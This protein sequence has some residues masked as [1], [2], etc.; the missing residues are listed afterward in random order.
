[1][2]R[3]QES[4]RRRGFTARHSRRRAAFGTYRGDVPRVEVRR[5]LQEGQACV[6]VHYILKT[7]KTK[8]IKSACRLCPSSLISITNPAAAAD[9]DAEDKRTSGGR[10]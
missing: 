3:D 5:L 10:D 2:T 9:T 1:M 6:R 7:H 4:E 8:G